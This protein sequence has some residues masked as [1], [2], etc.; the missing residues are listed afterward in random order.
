MRIHPF[1]LALSILCF[2]ACSVK[3][4]DPIE[5]LAIQPIPVKR[6]DT[7]F[8]ALDT[9]RIKDGMERL[10]KQYPLFSKDYFT[11]ILQIDPLDTIEIKNYYKVNLPVFEKM[12]KWHFP[13]SIHQD[14]NKALARFHYYFPDYTM[15]KELIYYLSPINTIHHVLGENYIGVGLQIT[16]LENYSSHQIPFYCIQNLLDD[17]LYNKQRESSLIYQMIE[18]GKR[19]Y[20]LNQICLNTPDSLLFNYTGLQ[21]KAVQEQESAIW[22]Y[23]IDQKILQSKERIDALNFL[24]ASE[25]NSLLGGALPG[26][27]GKYI[28]YKIVCAYMEKQQKTSFVNL[29]KLVQSSASEIYAEAGYHP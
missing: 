28:G 6:F 5:G 16:A 10:N 21:L 9:H 23:M 26:N 18:A 13:D 3:Q 17:Y 25:H 15:P 29:Q 7:A 1:W 22:Q 2:F 27:V 20:M 11:R 8:F 24:G 12:E 4:N 19:Q 14:L